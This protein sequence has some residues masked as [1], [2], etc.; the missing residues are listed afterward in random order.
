[1]CLTRGLPDEKLAPP[2]AGTPFEGRRR[3][4]P[5]PIFRCN[6]F[7]DPD[8]TG[9]PS[10][11]LPALSP[12]RR[13]DPVA[14]T[15]LAALLFLAVLLA[16][17]VALLDEQAAR[18]NTERASTQLVTA[19]RAA[20]AVVSRMEGDL[21]ARA[22]R[23]AVSP[24]LEQAIVSG[25]ETEVKAFVR[26]AGAG[27]S[28]RTATGVVGALPRRPR[29][30]ASALITRT[31]GETAQL[32][33]AESLTAA[34]LASIRR[35]TPRPPG[36]QVLLLWHGGV[37]GPAR[38]VPAALSADGRMRIGARTF[39]DSS[40]RLP[41]T[42]AEL[43]LA[44][45]VSAV[46]ART[47]AFRK[48]SLLAAALTLLVAAGVVLPLARPFSRLLGD[49]RER[50]E[51]DPLTGLANRRALEERLAEEL[52]RA[53]RHGTHLGLVLADVDDFKQINDRFGHQFGDTV[54]QAFAAAFSGTLREADLAARFGGEEF[55]LVLPGTG[56]ESACRVAE[57][58]RRAVGQVRL[59]VGAGAEVAVTAS[60]GVA[61]FPAC[62]GVGELVRLADEHLY[63]AKSS[64]KD[65][66]V[67]GEDQTNVQ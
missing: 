22:S 32:T 26:Q 62:A 65:R 13:R 42:E 29:L 59:P 21:A 34:T 4:L 7:V 15:A 1:V 64:G 60:F 46:S 31:G 40:V 28:I 18:T 39:L 23:L 56:A 8:M 14:R 49:L 12:A 19:T 37:I 51:R 11:A 63:R 2:P 9:Q 44:E 6:A 47:G 66:V 3:A 10:L 58:I 48:R 57:E 24:A 5:R 27:A 17:I 16:G 43:V 41:G 25:D 38:D 20:D 67:G 53:R 50:A 52:E 54:L 30:A 55:A 36:A 35:K 61:A 45:P 33:V